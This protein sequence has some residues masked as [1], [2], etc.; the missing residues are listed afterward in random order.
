MREIYPTKAAPSI[1][2]INSKPITQEQYNALLAQIQDYET[3]VN[4]ID[5]AFTQLK[6]DLQSAWTTQTLT[7]DLVNAITACLDNIEATTVQATTVQASN[8]VFACH[9]QGT[10]AYMQCLTTACKVCTPTVNADNVN[11]SCVNTSCVVTD[12]I[13]VNNAVNYNTT[14]TA[15]AT[16]TNA[17]VSC[18]TITDASIH[19]AS[20]FCL[21]ADTV[22]VALKQLM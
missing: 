21:D 18:A 20:V 22:Q 1:S 5:A 17:D 7:A 12:N 9:F 16:I 2:V 10:T 6:N 11:T 15:C 19:K 13:T 14:N 3:N 4:N 8:A